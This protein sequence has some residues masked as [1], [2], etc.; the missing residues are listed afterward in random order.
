MAS[1]HYETDAIDFTAK[2]SI[3]EGKV[4]VN[5]DELSVDEFPDYPAVYRI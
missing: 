1:A 4:S 2:S 5:F 3:P